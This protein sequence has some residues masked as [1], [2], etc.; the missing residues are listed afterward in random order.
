[1]ISTQG[2]RTRHGLQGQTQQQPQGQR[3][4]QYLGSQVSRLGLHVMS[5]QHK[6]Q[7]HVVSTGCSHF[8]SMQLVCQQGVQAKLQLEVQVGLQR[9]LE[10]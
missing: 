5:S 6:T 2:A 3:A 7:Q 8:D 10:R 9:R 4:V 1:M